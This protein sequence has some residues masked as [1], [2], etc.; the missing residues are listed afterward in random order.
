MDAIFLDFYRS[1]DKKIS[2]YL[3]V[4]DNQVEDDD[5]I[6][7]PSGMRFVELSISIGRFR[8]HPVT[9]I[10]LQGIERHLRHNRGFEWILLC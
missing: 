6:E 4:T 8:L 5:R 2:F 10:Q 1:H 3:V 9:Q 7:F